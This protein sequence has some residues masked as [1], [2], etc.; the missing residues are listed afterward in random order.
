MPMSTRR[1]W[2]RF[3]LR[4]L[5]LVVTLLAV[6][7]GW[8]VH[9]VRQQKAALAELRITQGVYSLPAT[10]I[11]WFRVRD[12]QSPIP[13]VSLVRRL[14]GDD[15]LLVIVCPPKLRPKLKSQLAAFPEARIRA[16][17]YWEQ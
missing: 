10:K 7:L 15:A 3:S 8:N 5:L 2:L 11:G 1:H 4:G 16:D 14:L 6:W 9:V 17:S 12:S 13:R